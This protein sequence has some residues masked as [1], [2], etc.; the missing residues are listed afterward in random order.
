[1]I[2]TVYPP[3]FH[4]D[5]LRWEQGWE[6]TL[7]GWEEEYSDSE[8]ARGTVE[9]GLGTG[10]W[11]LET[12]HK[13]LQALREK[14]KHKHPELHKKLT[15]FEFH[16]G[17]AKTA[18]LLCAGR[19]RESI[20]FFLTNREF[21]FTYDYIVGRIGDDKL[22]PDARAV[23]TKLVSALFVDREPYETFDANQKARILPSIT[24]ASL[25][26]RK[27]NLVDPY[28]DSNDEDLK[29]C[30]WKGEIGHCRHCHSPKDDR[31]LAC[32]GSR[33]A[34]RFKASAMAGGKRVET[35]VSVVRPEKNFSK[36]KEVLL[37]VM[38]DIRIIRASELHVTYLLT[39]VRDHCWS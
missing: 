28:T 34:A 37:H 1:M 10:H 16:L 33:A 35:T 3:A 23:F 39:E 27:P 29:Y 15:E 9:I 2:V 21:M 25:K 32:I 38:K 36:L 19:H 7:Q 5:K 8:I 30:D 17:F 26:L 14:G 4:Q 6:D 11:E 31:T 22:A 18:A 13:N 20:D 24:A 12:R